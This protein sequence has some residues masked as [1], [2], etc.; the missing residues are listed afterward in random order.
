MYLYISMAISCCKLTNSLPPNLQ[1]FSFLI[2]TKT[3]LQVTNY[4][5][6][7]PNTK[8]SRS[9]SPDNGH[10]CQKIVCKI[11]NF[12]SKFS[13]F[14]FGYYPFLTRSVSFSAAKFLRFVSVRWFEVTLVFYIIK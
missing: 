7:E 6:S 9:P 4:E 2:P 5:E 1:K 8:H 14:S 13:E 10:W 12:Y 11:H 3:E